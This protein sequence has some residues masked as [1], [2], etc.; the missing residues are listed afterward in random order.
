MLLGLVFILGPIVTTTSLQEYFTQRKT[1]GFLLF[2]ATLYDL[3]W[4]IPGVFDGT[5]L[6]GSLWTLPVEV[7]C[8]LILGLLGWVGAL[9]FD[10]TYLFVAIVLSVLT[11]TGLLDLI[12]APVA[13]SFLAGVS[14]WKWRGRI[15][16]NGPFALGMLLFSL[17]LMHYR[18][19]FS[20]AMLVL[21]LAYGSLYTAY[22]PAGAIRRFNRFGDY[23]YGIYI[24]AF[25]VQVTIHQLWPNFGVAAMFV[26]A[27][28]IT[29]IL[30]VMSWTLIESPA[31]HRGEKWADLTTRRVLSVKDS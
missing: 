5:A 30:A 31:L 4:T 28:P 2:N 7:R 22:I 19:P 18:A 8:Y 10:I 25:P 23:S 20:S 15:V 26:F 16:L 6:N 17:I 9:R 3:R 24:Y 11:F 1:W 13:F 12:Q 21:G 27:M 29:L 14:A